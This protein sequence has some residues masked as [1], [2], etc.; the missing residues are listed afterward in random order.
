[1]RRW[2]ACALFL[3][4]PTSSLAAMQLKGWIEWVQKVEMRVLE[5]GV[6]EEVVVAAGQRV[7]QG[8]LLLRMDQREAKANRLEMRARVARAK[9]GTEKARRELE[10]TQELFDRGLIAA[11]EL[12]DAE[13]KGAAA[14]AD[15][16]AAKAAEAAAE[17]AL[18]RTELRA[19]FDGVVVARNA[20]RGEVVY[21]TLQQ[22]PLLV[23]APDDKLLARA[24]VTA[25]VLRLHRP[26]QAARVNVLGQA[27]E[28]RIYSLGV[29]AVRVELQGAVY[30]LDVIFERHPN[31]LLRPSEAVQI[32]L[33]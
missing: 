30:P 4:I 29:E 14:D 28:A 3:S 18:E 7:K 26:G 2:L 6:V 11:E 31:E 16:Q 27:R 22:E 15:E 12:K 9:I 20:W 23:V 10:R 5:S 13:L 19:P 25:E 8:E 24:L 17:V 33:P 1:M 32:L 21:K